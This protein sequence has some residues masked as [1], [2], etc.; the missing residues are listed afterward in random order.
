M[1]KSTL[2]IVRPEPLVSPEIEQ[3]PPKYLQIAN[4]LRDL[5]IR[6]EL[7]P[8][9][10]VPSE[11]V[12]TEEWKVSRPTA[13]RAL[14]ALRVE[15]LVE[16]RQGSGTYVRRQPALYRRARDRYTRARAT[17]KIYTAGEWAKIVDA[18][19]QGAPADVA[20]ALEIEPGSDAIARRRITHEGDAPVEVS[21]SWFRREVG[22]VA[23]LLL[24][25]ERIKEGTVA[26][27]ER[28]TGRRAVTATDRVTA[29]LATERERQELAIPDG[30]AAVLL[31]HHTTF[32]VDGE[33]I[34]FAEA[35]YP[36]GRWS[37]EEQYSLP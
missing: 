5:I 8:G 37:F 24:E 6:G 31:V 35:V 13:T 22:Q 21:T 27:V 25:R 26:Y 15:G 16:A 14:A 28:S 29:R 34:E 10:E 33:P 30:V 17:G 12:I 11:R 3:S 1:A 19:V 32:D 9:D 36:A 4:H 7:E 23:P 18:G 2:H 20:L